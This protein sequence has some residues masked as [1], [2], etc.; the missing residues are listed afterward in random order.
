MHRLPDSAAGVRGEYRGVVICV[1]T[2]VE[3]GD[4]DVQNLSSK[5][6]RGRHAQRRAIDHG[7]PTSRLWSAET[8]Q[9]SRWA[10]VCRSEERR[11]R[12][13]IDRH[14]LLRPDNDLIAD[15]KRPRRAERPRW[16]SRSSMGSSAGTQSARY[17]SLAMTANSTGA[18]KTARRAVAP[19]ALGDRRHSTCKQRRPRAGQ[20]PGTHCRLVVASGSDAHCHRI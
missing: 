17:S 9:P 16:A 18:V 4:H 15:Q 20:R 1:A 8:L 3:L 7:S 19:A 6:Q 12:E 5:E 13:G 2:G 10:G 11:A 14:L